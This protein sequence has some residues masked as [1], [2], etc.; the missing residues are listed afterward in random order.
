MSFSCRAW[1]HKQPHL[2]FVVVEQTHVQKHSC[3][4][5]AVEYSIIYRSTHVVYRNPLDTK[6]IM[7]DEQVGSFNWVSFTEA[8]AEA[9]ETQDWLL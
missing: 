4:E 6:E 7:D 3:M 5:F 2:I 8:E 1:K 9:V